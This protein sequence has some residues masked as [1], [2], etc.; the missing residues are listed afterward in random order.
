MARQKRI[1]YAQMHT[2]P[3]KIRVMWDR[4]VEEYVC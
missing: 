2:G 3:I 4:S 1:I